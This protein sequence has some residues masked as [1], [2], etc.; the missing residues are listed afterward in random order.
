M[1]HTAQAHPPWSPWPRPFHY[2]YAA[3]FLCG[4]LRPSEREDPVN[5]G[6]Y[7]TAIN[8]H[9]PHAHPVPIRKKA[10]LLYRAESPEEAVEQPTPPARP[11]VVELAEDFGLEIDCKDIRQVLLRDGPRAPEF[12]KGWVVVETLTDMPLEVVAV[13]TTRPHTSPV[14]RPRP[15]S[16]RIGCREP[17]R[18]CRASS[19]R[20]PQ[21]QKLVV[22]DAGHGGRDPGAEGNRL[23]EKDLTLSICQQNRT[24]LGYD[25]RLASPSH[26][27]DLFLSL[28]DRR[29]F[30]NRSQ[31]DY[32]VS[33]HVNKGRG[34]ATTTTS[35]GSSG[36]LA[37]SCASIRHPRC[38]RGS[39]V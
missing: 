39:A 27:T 9:N 18:L 19:V 28:A 12:I 30:A 11:V 38:G 20:V 14:C 7:A 4:D 8:V 6:S 36:Y 24:D 16:L 21:M 1:A 13:Y 37:G 33:I 35:S 25:Y 3:K 31:P 17:A 10:I 29:S 2:V 32:F 26:A 23:R 5:P 22:L 34:E 15:R